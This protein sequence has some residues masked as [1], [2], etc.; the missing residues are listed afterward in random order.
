MTFKYTLKD[1]K[2]LLNW[3][4][5]VKLNEQYYH[6]K[7]DIHHIYSVREN[8]NVKVFATPYNHP[9]GLTLIITG[10]YIFHASLRKA[11]NH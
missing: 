11:T 7:F 8:R 5:F 6:A 4:E 2:C 3:Y 9:A 1:A 10:I